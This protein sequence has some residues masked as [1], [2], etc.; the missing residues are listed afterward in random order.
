MSYLFVLCSSPFMLWGVY[1]TLQLSLQGLS[2]D[3]QRNPS[4]PQ[5]LESRECCGKRWFVI[6]VDPTTH[7]FK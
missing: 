6:Y 5:I 1:P 2:N 4:A 7:L 3:E